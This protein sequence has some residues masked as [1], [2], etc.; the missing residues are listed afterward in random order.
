MNIFIYVILISSVACTCCSSK[1]AFLSGD[2]LALNSWR[3]FNFSTQNEFDTNAVF[4]RYLPSVLR[5][6]YSSSTKSFPYYDSMLARQ[7]PRFHVEYDIVDIP[8]SLLCQV[9]NSNSEIEGNHYYYYSGDIMQSS[10]RQLR[11]DTSLGKIFRNASAMNRLT[12]H[13][14]MGSRDVKAT[15][16]YDAV[17][18]IF[19]QM[20][21]SKKI[22]LV[23]PQFAPCMALQGRYHPFACQSRFE[24]PASCTVIERSSF[25]L[26]RQEHAPDIE[27]DPQTME[28]SYSEYCRN[29]KTLDVVL[30]PMQILYI[31]P[32]WFHDAQALECSISVSLWWDTGL[33]KIMTGN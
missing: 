1:P 22:R 33:E 15:M 26:N 20:H 21:G 19:V 9:Q 17:H 7:Q 29:L 10:F 28:G 25:L 13:M 27:L 5:N 14:W 30:Q 11:V 31:P 3:F 18:N 24:D 23:P 32:F 4:G 2:G 8:S 16:H 12:A 6:A